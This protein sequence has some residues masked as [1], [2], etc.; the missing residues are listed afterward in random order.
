MPLKQ[1][2]CLHTYVCNLPDQLT[3]YDGE[4]IT[5]DASGNPTNYLGATLV[6]EGQRLKSYTP[7]A[8]SSGRSNSYVY[9]YDEN[10]I[11]TRK[12]IGSTVTDYYYNGTLLMGTVK[13]TTNS[14][15]STTTSKLRFSYDADGKVVAVNYNGNYY[16]YLRNAQS[17]IVKLIDKTGA[18]VV[19]Y[20]YDSWGKL[21]STS[22]SLASTL[23]KNNPFRYRGYV[24]DEETGFYYLQSR[25]YNPEVGRFISSDVLLSTGQGVLGHNAYA[26]CLNNP[27]NMSDNCGSYAEAIKPLDG[28]GG[29]SLGIGIGIG[30]LILTIISAITNI[31][32]SKP[33]VKTEKEQAYFTTNPMDFNPVGLTRTMYPGTKNGAIIKWCDPTNGATVFEWNEDLKHGSHYHVFMPNLNGLHDGTHYYPGQRVPEPWNSLYF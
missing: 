31:T 23:G 14:N 33:K 15:G 8:A 1:P 6:W 11:R 16:Y 32:T 26:Y 22:G 5:Y 10:G 2:Y 17:D 20:T 12:T 27:V 13:T 7:K 29:G 24:Y 19:E 9:S 21:L 25:Y 18:T 30:S 28:A 3:S 4:S